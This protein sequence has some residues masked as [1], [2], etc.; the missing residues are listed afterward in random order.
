[1]GSGGTQYDNGDVG[2]AARW[3]QKQ[4]F[5]GTGAQINGLGTTYPGQ[6]VYCTSTGN[7]FTIDVMY[8]RN[9]ANSAWKVMG[10]ITGEIKAWGGLQASPPAGYLLCDGSAVSRTTYADLF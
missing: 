4:L 6:M 3:N 10:A 8:R 7:G 9:A 1:M 5:V 2:G